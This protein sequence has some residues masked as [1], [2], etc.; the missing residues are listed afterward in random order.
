M[1]P[2]KFEAPGHARP[3]RG[4]R[5]SAPPINPTDLIVHAILHGA[6]LWVGLQPTSAGFL[7][8]PNDPATAVG[9]PAYN[10]PLASKNEDLRGHRPL[11]PILPKPHPLPCR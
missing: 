4:L 11:G 1:V 2:L 6:N 7:P 9:W 10:K 3:N 8:M 5:I